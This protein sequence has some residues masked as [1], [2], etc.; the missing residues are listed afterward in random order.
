MVS[1]EANQKKL[2]E[3]NQPY[4]LYNH[5]L[6]LDKHNRLRR[7][8]SKCNRWQLGD[9]RGLNC[10]TQCSYVT[11]TYYYIT[12][13]WFICTTWL[14]HTTK[15]PANVTVRQCSWQITMCCVANSSQSLLIRNLSIAFLF[16]LMQCM[17]E[18][19]FAPHCDRCL[20]IA[21]T[22]STNVSY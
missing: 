2:T 22:Q 21:L 9:V 11:C 1:D 19:H 5:C 13:I 20:G 14:C 7:I 17:F 3:M 15:L 4:F 16:M 18:V 8:C 6:L 12:V 10:V